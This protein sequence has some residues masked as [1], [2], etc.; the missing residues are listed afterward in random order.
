M[1]P[2]PDPDDRRKVLVRTTA[3]GDALAGATRAQ[4]TSWLD[5][6]LQALSAEDRA[7]IAR[8]TA[9]LSSIADS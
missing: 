6:R 3:E 5:R 8:A 1:L 2:T 7:M 4:R 9:L